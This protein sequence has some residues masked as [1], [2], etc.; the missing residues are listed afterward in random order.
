[1]KKLLFIFGL[2]TAMIACSPKTT[3]VIEE[4]G[5]EYPTAQIGEGQGLYVS[6]CAK[7][8][9]LPVIKKYSKERW[10]QILPK[11]VV[12]AK[13]TDEE[14]DKVQAYVYWELEK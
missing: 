14:A 11:M 10:Q 8:H 2:T 9:D 3:E 7:C 13:L 6:N 4:K 1:M 12:K 5:D